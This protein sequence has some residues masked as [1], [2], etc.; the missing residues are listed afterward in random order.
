MPDASKVY[1]SVLNVVF[2]KAELARPDALP[3]L[4][5]GPVVNIALPAWPHSLAALSRFKVRHCTLELEKK[6]S[7]VLSRAYS[8]TGKGR[9]FR[10]IARGRGMINP[11]RLKKG[12]SG[13]I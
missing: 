3:V 2:E 9:W 12:I 8:G 4:E 5:V 13:I 6:S 7:S 10:S 1:F 11:G